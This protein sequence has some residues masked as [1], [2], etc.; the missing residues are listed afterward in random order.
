MVQLGRDFKA[1]FPA[2]IGN[3]YSSD[4]FFFRHT[5]F[6]R[7]EGSYKAF[8]EGL[9]GDQAYDS[10]TLDPPPSTD[11]DVLLMVCERALN[12]RINYLY[13][14]FSHMKCVNS[15]GQTIIIKMVPMGN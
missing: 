5:D 6:Q 14:Y 8:A 11:A 4:K 10:I 15:L 7:S 3:E 12:S 13:L 1:A 2:L 9:F